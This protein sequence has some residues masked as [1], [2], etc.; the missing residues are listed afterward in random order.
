M[1]EVWLS[2]NLTCFS[3]EGSWQLQNLGPGR[4]WRL[5][6]WKNKEFKGRR[7][8]EAKLRGKT[9]EV[10]AVLRGQVV[11]KLMVDDSWRDSWA[12]DPTATPVTGR[13]GTK[14]A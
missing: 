14:F 13:D 11:N 5:W 2:R 9:A 10:G 6:Y 7:E 8:E 12:K 1:W 4:H 3:F